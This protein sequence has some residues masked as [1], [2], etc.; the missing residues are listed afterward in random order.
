MGRD[1]ALFGPLGITAVDWVTDRAGEP[2]AAPGLC[3]RPRDAAR[4]GQLVLVVVV[5]AGNY[6]QPE[7]SRLPLAILNQFALP[8]LVGRQGPDSP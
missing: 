4:I 5:T 8:A 1:A 7:N 2:V 3:L 6:N